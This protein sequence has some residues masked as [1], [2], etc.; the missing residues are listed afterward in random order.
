MSFRFTAEDYDQAIERL[1]LGKKQLE[2]D[3]N[4]CAICGDD[5]AAFECRF[6]P[7]V[8]MKFCEMIGRDANS[9]HEDLHRLLAWMNEQGKDPDKEPSDDYDFTPFGGI[10]SG[11]HWLA[12]KYQVMSQ[13]IG[14]GMI[15][16][17]E[18]ERLAAQSFEDHKKN[19]LI[20][21][22]A[23]AEELMSEDELQELER[24]C[25]REAQEDK[26]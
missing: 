8:A 5:C 2:H 7:L 25:Y 16:T 24:E 18:A 14:P 21:D 15:V 26:G 17:P 23:R 10:H 3:G 19:K 22:A 9:I 12:G 6:N 13:W 4:C 1:Q 11:L 20:S